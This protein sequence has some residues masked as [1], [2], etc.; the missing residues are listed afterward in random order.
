ML[1]ISQERDF[2]YMFILKTNNSERSGEKVKKIW[3]Q[4][5][6]GINHINKEI[7]YTYVTMYQ[8]IKQ[9]LQ[10][11][12]TISTYLSSAPSKFHC[13]RPV[14]EADKT[15]L[16][17]ERRFEWGEREC[18][19]WTGLLVSPLRN[20]TGPVVW[21]TSNMKTEPFCNNRKSRRKISESINRDYYNK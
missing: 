12:Y 5:E 8:W 21:R 13:H 16:R 14:E 7:K 11:K 17:P 20:F 2:L 18:M 19:V 10:S 15:V 6:N 4:E 3:Q 1:I 9:D